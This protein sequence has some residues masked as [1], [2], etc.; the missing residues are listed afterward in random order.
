LRTLE[1]TLAPAETLTLA[2]ETP[3]AASTHDAQED[4][5]LGI[6]RTDAILASAAIGGAGLLVATITGIIGLNAQVTGNNEC[7]SLTHTCTQ[8]G[9]DANQRAKT[10][11]IISSTGFIV[12]LLGGGAA[13][14]L[15]V[16]TPSTNDSTHTA[17]LAVGGKW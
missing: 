16:T 1:F 3:P 7:S 11:A 17:M 12:T 10:M 4:H 15:Y 8:T 5:V 2:L 13:T 6:K 14:Y 9:Y